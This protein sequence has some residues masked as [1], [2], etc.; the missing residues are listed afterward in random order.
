VSPKEHW[1][2]I[3]SNNPPER[4]NKEV[5]RRTNVV[6]IFPDEAAIIPRRT[7]LGV[8]AVAFP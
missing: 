7:E 3:W 8:E 5:K 2:K 4:V 1:Q 6:D